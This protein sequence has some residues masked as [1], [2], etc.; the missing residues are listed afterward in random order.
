MKKCPYCA[1]EIQDKAVKCK[2]CGEWLL[3]KQS[4][5]KRE[6]ITPES[7]IKPVPKDEKINEILRQGNMFVDIHGIPD[8]PEN[9]PDK[10]LDCPKNKNIPDVMDAKTYGDGVQ[11]K[12]RYSPFQ[13]KGW[14]IYDMVITKERIIVVRTTFRRSVVATVGV[15]AAMVLGAPAAFLLGKALEKYEELTKDRKLDL[16]IIDSLISNGV[17]IAGNAKDI[18]KVVIA[19]EKLSFWE[20]HVLDLRSTLRVVVKGEFLYK[21]DKLKGFIAFTSGRGKK[22]TNKLFENNFPVRVIVLD[23]KVDKDSDYKLLV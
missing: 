16:D 4:V 2:H 3:Q 17:A 11:R 12:I 21:S 19:E 15:S 10:L 18:E 23:E 14:G 22:D 5:L 13:F 1:E 20:A 7:G 9:L 6:R 8:I